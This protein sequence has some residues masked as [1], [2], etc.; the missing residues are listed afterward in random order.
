MFREKY[1]AAFSQVHGDRTQ[2]DK[3]FNIAEESSS[4][5][6]AKIYPFRY[7]G[8]LAAAV[9]IVLVV[10]LYPN[11]SGFLKT[12]DVEYKPLG[13]VNYGTEK[14]WD[15]AVITSGAAPETKTVVTSDVATYDLKAEQSKA[16][17][18]PETQTETVTSY[19]ADVAEDAS[20]T[21]NVPMMAMQ[22][23][24]DAIPEEAAENEKIMFNK[25]ASGGGSSAQSVMTDESS[26][27]LA[28][29][30]TV[31]M[32][33]YIRDAEISVLLDESG[34]D[35]GSYRIMVIQEGEEQIAYAE[36]DGTLY[37]F[38]AKGLTAEEL[39]QFV[40]EKL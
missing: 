5:K 3:I 38:T 28:D 34:E 33:V 30:K 22:A 20:V 11:F 31:V 16:E 36:K 19:N 26:F 29:G 6:K 2:I 10:A 23:T 21:A 13:V 12:E 1:K 18:A 24:D 40:S 32:T 37:K 8:T 9:A 17:K 15:D 14:T 7:A 39:K 4:H 25:R 35:M 27:E